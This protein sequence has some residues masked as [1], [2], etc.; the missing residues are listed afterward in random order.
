MPSWPDELPGPNVI[1]HVANV[2]FDKVPTY[3]K[4]IHRGAFF[5]SLRVFPSHE[6]F[7]VSS[8]ADLCRLPSGAAAAS[9]HPSHH[10]QS[11]LGISPGV[12]SFSPDWR[13]HE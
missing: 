11:Y 4:M 2:F 7:P 9:C 6:N 8:I 1:E 3:P 12:A 5:N 13:I 10:G